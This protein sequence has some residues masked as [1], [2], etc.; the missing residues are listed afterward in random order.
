MNHNEKAKM[1]TFFMPVEIAGP[2]WE[3]F[4]TVNALV[5]TG[6]TYS[7]MPASLLTSL[8]VAPFDRYGFILAN[9][10]RVYRDVGDVIIRIDGRARPTVAVF[11]DEGSHA[12]LGAFTLA[13]FSVA[14]DT[15]NQC[16]IPTDA[17]GIRA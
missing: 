1:G 7:M 2:D 15:V 12:I 13:A 16:L 8:G 11:A 3:R 14:V 6:A 17:I 9:G 5:D 4:E 10:Q